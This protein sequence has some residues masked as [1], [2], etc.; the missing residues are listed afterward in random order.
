M[1]LPSPA[2]QQLLRALVRPGSFPILHGISPCLRR[3]LWH[4]LL[5]RQLVCALWKATA[6]AY[7]QLRLAGLCAGLICFSR[8]AQPGRGPKSNDICQQEPHVH[9]VAVGITA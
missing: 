8:L 7:S 2:A 9:P 5:A 4:D 3:H 1:N 6:E